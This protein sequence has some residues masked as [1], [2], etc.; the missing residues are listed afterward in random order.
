MNK[1]PIAAAKRPENAGSYSLGA[2]AKC[3]EC[4]G[5]SESDEFT[6]QSIMRDIR[7]CS[8]RTCPL[9]HLRGWSK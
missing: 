9:H 8:S 5:G 3:Y 4:L 6:K 7:E 1:N 2:K